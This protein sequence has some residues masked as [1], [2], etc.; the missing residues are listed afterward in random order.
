MNFR[1]VLKEM[2]HLTNPKRKKTDARP[3]KK[4]EI[5]IEQ[6]NSDICVV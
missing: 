5:S 4:E 6:N 2:L 3:K 1:P